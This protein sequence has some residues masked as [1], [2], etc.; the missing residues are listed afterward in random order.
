MWY[1]IL[2]VLLKHLIK[3]EKG[4]LGKNLILIRLTY[5]N[6]IGVKCDKL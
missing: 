6:I 4:H 5:C 3:C 2:Y 1:L